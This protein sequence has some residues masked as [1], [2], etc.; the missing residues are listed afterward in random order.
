[1]T[2]DQIDADLIE[3]ERLA[4]CVVDQLKI[5]HRKPASDQTRG[6]SAREALIALRF[7]VQLVAVAALNVTQGLVLSAQDL[8][9]VLVAWARI[10]A[11]LEGAGL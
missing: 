6:I 8:A 10:E 11:I 3:P 5:E 4:A 2:L 9:R 1:M 7:E